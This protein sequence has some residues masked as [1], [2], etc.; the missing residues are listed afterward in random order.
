MK[1]L[2]EPQYQHGQ[3]DRSGVLLVNLGTPRST[4]T[5]DVRRY[6]AQFLSDP[7]IVELPRWLWNLILHGVILRFRPRRSAEAYRSV[8]TD[9]G[10]PLMTGSVD[11]C[12]AVR[13]HLREAHGLAV[14]V[15]LAMRYGEPSVR[16]ALDTLREQGVRRLLV[17][18][19]YPQYSGT[20]VASVFDE[21]STML[22]K[23]RWIPELRTINQ[24]FDRPDYIQA[25]ANSITTARA[26]HG[27]GQLLVFSFHGI[28]ERYLLN[29][30]PYHCQCHKTARLTAERLGLAADQYRVVFQSRFGRERWLH[31]Y[32]DE[33]MKALPGEGVK[34]IDVICPA[35]SIDCLETLEEIADENREYFMEA[36]G[37]RYHYIPCL[38]DNPEHVAVLSQLLV[39]HMGGW[40]ELSADYDATQRQQELSAQAPAAEAMRAA[41]PG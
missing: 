36:G 9:D 41:L 1:Y 35:F 15:E 13:E 25:L 37:E 8:W 30:D 28:P 39:Q 22:Q 10:S 11:L 6:L 38:N 40:P 26:E 23:T 16:T 20:T 12:A 18:P 19:L 21:V 24:Y 4:E 34:S 3:L 2:G 27:S 32:C 7:R 29:G 31:P 33:T 5:R 17:L 14:P